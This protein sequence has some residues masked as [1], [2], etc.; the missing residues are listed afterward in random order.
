MP[1][2]PRNLKALLDKAVATYNQPG[3]IPNDP[4]SIP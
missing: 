2:S 4:I 1:S 3:F